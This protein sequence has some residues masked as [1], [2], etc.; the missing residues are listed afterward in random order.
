MKKYLKAIDVIILGENM[1]LGKK[2]I[3]AV[4]LFLLVG[5]TIA[6]WLF[7]SPQQ[8]RGF[9]IYLSESNELVTSEED[10]V[11]Y[12]KTSHEIKLTAEGVEKIKALKVPVTGSPFVIKI[13]SKEIYAGSFWTS[14][15][16]LSYSGI[17]IDTSKIQEDTIKIEKGYPSLDFFKGE[18]PRNNFEIFNY[19]QKKGKLVQ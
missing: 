12:N 19:L 7:L 8:Q 4:I 2:L 10:I 13:D 15:S 9:G 1:R 17:V 6:A 11:S 3:L 16:S 14:I 5:I 18:D